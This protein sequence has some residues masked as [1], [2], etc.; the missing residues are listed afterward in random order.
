MPFFAPRIVDLRIKDN[1]R[2]KFRLLNPPDT[3]ENRSRGVIY[4][5]NYNSVE[6][7]KTSLFEQIPRI[8]TEL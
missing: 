1:L 6:A 2:S 4:R 5:T 8:V 7:L 3:L